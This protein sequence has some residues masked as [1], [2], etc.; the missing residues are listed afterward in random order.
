MLVKRH[1]IGT[2][3]IETIQTREVSKV[4]M[5]KLE[6]D[7]SLVELFVAEDDTTPEIQKNF[8]IVQEKY[9]ILY[10]YDELEYVGSFSIR[11]GLYT[12]W[13]FEIKSDYI[14]NIG[15]PI[16][17]I[18]DVEINIVQ[19]IIK[20]SI[21]KWKRLPKPDLN[22]TFTEEELKDMHPERQLK[23]ILIKKY[24]LK[25]RIINKLSVDNQIR[26]IIQVQNGD[27]CSP[28]QLLHTQKVK[29][30]LTEESIKLSIEDQNN[31]SVETHSNEEKISEDINIET[32]TVKSYVDN[33]VTIFDSIEFPV[34]SNNYKKIS[35][36]L[37]IPNKYVF[38]NRYTEI[39]QDDNS[40]NVILVFSN[41]FDNQ[42]I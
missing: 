40:S 2:K 28:E 27:D 33:Q 1:L 11:N 6:N 42:L 10:S 34:A 5:V 29:E 14:K 35:E 24:N 23:Y 20:E 22:K 41:K 32:E 13:V 38:L 26:Y 39:T 36:K 3:Q 16:K 15:T 37:E 17:K 12:F 31:I 7:R 4:L 8:L 21:K 30:N 25:G 9:R 19:P 18:E